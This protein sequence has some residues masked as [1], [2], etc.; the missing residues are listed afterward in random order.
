M[1]RLPTLLV[2]TSLTLALTGCAR[3]TVVRE[4]VVDQSAGSSA[5]A[6]S[7][8]HRHYRNL[9]RIAGRDMRCHPNRVFVQEASP[10]IFSVQGCGILREYV[11]V[12]RHRR[13]CRWHGIQPVEQVAM[14]EARCGAGPAQ[15]TVTGP[16][17][18]R[19]SVCGQA[20]DYALA[21]G[22]VGCGWARGTS[23]QVMMLQTEPGTSVIVLADEVGPAPERAGSDEDDVVLELGAAGTLQSVLAAQYAA[24]R[25]CTQGTSVTL[26]IRWAAD[27]TVSVGLAPPYAGTPME[28]CVRQ[29]LGT[30]RIQATGAAG[31]LHATL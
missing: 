7:I 6:S 27:G 26:T 2:L 13:H 23:A 17:T 30:V 21:C 20:I 16:L 19:V 28:A 1:I 5:P 12:C 11:M 8:S 24:L 22:P 9:L 15:L 4:V 3:R 14:A 31:E 29:V 18:R 10:G 25:A